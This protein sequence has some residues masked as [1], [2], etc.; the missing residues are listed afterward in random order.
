MKNKIRRYDY[1]GMW[2]RKRRSWEDELKGLYSDC[3]V[4]SSQGGG[5]HV[6]LVRQN[7]RMYITVSSYGSG[8][9]GYN[10]YTH[11][12]LNEEGVEELQKKLKD[13]EKEKLNELIE[14]YK[15]KGYVF[16]TEL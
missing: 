6:F 1:V 16:V 12:V 2:E 5:G 10:W 13:D 7:K 9:G 3:F 4:I 11:Y 8:H 14:K 15:K